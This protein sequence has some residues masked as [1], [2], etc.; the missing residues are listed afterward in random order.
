MRGILNLLGE[1]C[2]KTPQGA[3][4]RPPGIRCFGIWIDWS[5]GGGLSLRRTLPGDG[6]S[7]GDEA[8]ERNHG[9]PVQQADQIGKGEEGDRPAAAPPRGAEKRGRVEG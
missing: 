8:E 5:G 4:Y 2:G 1:N 9:G 6:L 3:P 7:P